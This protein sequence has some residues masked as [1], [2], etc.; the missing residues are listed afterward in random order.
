MI[1]LALAGFLLVGLCGAAAWGDPRTRLINVDTARVIDDG[2]WQYG[3]DLRTFGD[4]DDEEYLSGHIRY[5]THGYQLEVLGSFARRAE[6]MTGVGLL[7][8][9][10][11][12]VELRAKKR[13]MRDGNATLSAIAGVEFPNTPAQDGEH[14]AL[15]LPLTIDAGSATCGH[16]V[17]KFVFLEDNTVSILG[18]AVEHVLSDEVTL[19]AELAPTLGGS[20]TRN[21]RNAL[22]EDS[23]WGV[24]ARWTPGEDEEWQLDLGITNGKGQTTS[25]GAAPGI[26]DSTAVYLA[27]TRTR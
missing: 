5:A 14:L 17:P 18:L 12:N 9:G 21:R 10:G 15:H 2:R 24:G 6:Q 11:T 22:A 19:M 1:A 23:V 26:L 7:R 16:I 13:L 20:N 25:F 27:V 8:Y 3:V 4:A